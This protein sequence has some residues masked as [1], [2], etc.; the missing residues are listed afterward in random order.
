MSKDEQLRRYMERQEYLFI[1]AWMWEW[2]HGYERDCLE[3]R[4]RRRNQLCAKM[5]GV[6]KIPTKIVDALVFCRPVLH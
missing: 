6:R 4:K 5:F 1:E 2:R 3:M